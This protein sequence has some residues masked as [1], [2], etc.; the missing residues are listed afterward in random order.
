[1]SRY[2]RSFTF[3]SISLLIAGLASCSNG[4]V[5]QCNQLIGVANQAVTEVEAVTSNSAPRDTETFSSITEAAQQAAAQLEAI[6]LTDEQ[7]QSYRQRFIKLYSETGEATEQLVTAV[8]GQNL[9][10]AQDAYTLLE[11]ATSQEEPLVQEVNQY[12]QSS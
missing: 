1:M 2:R 3:L 8:E 5:D 11:D 9:P 12:C 10:A 7:L 6:D 4:K